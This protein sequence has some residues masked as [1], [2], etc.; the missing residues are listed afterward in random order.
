VGWGWVEDGVGV[1][2]RTHDEAERQFVAILGGRRSVRV[3]E[4]I[5]WVD[6]D[7]RWGG[8]KSKDWEG[9]GLWSEE[10]RM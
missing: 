8:R 7:G 9:V 1:G 3:G 2:A 10:V 5:F 4:E 6:A